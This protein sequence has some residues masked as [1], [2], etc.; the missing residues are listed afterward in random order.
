MRYSQKPFLLW[1]WRNMKQNKQTPV[2]AFFISSF[3]H[4]ECGTSSFLEVPPAMYMLPWLDALQLCYSGWNSQKNFNWNLGNNLVPRSVIILL[5]S[6][7]YSFLKLGTTAER[8]RGPTTPKCPPSQRPKPRNSS[9]PPPRTPPCCS[10]LCLPSRILFECN[11][12]CAK[13]FRSRLFCSENALR[14]PKSMNEKLRI[15]HAISPH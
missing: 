6:S 4:T 11:G 15:S 1:V 9:P 12:C 7:Y 14:S 5:L 3:H 8:I 10:G 2:H 13:S